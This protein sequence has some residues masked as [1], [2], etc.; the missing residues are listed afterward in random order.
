MLLVRSGGVFG[1]F[2]A[3]IVA[4]IFMFVVRPAINDTTDRAFDTA[5]RALDQA[6]QQTD[7]IQSTIAEATERGDYLSPASFRAAVND[8]EAE[9]GP[10]AELLDLTV[11]REGGGS[12]KYR[13]GDKA[14]GFT[15]GPGR[16]GLEPVDVTLIGSGKLEDNVF[17]I[18]ELSP[19]AAAK[20]AATVTAKAGEDF[21][22]ETMTLGLTPVTG[23]VKWTVT[24]E[25]DGRSLVFTANADGSHVKAVN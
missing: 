17:P 1:V 13:S 14:A 8:I 15:W 12:V 6:R 4:G 24:G 19:D 9:L 16:D 18:A 2:V 11:S 3:L 10:D 20:L 21:E 22:I 7:D 5:N 25:G 23:A